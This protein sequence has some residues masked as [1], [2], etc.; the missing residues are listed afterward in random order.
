MPLIL[1][2]FVPGYVAI[3]VYKWFWSDRT[4]VSDELI[5]AGVLSFISKTIVDVALA[6]LGLEC[7]TSIVALWQILIM[8]ASGIFAGMFTTSKI[9]NHITRKAV[10]RVFYN[11]CFDDAT[12][13]RQSVSV[14][15]HTKDSG[16]VYQGALV[17]QDGTYLHMV[18]YKTNDESI[19]PR[20]I[21]H[22]FHLLV[23]LADVS[24]IEILNQ[25]ECKQK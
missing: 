23:P 16:R 8:C 15:V 21:E 24:A 14:R 7:L 6:F 13:Y 1:Q 11:N 18:N 22:G 9:G 17:N 4:S 2:Y 25:A 5:L 12:D 19:M 20:D 10:R 3:K